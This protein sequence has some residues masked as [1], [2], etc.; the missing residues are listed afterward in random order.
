MMNCFHANRRR[1]AA[2]V[3]TLLLLYCAT[4]L[5]Q[6]APLP[7]ITSVSAATNSPVAGASDLI[8]IMVSPANQ[9]GATPTGTVAVVVD[10]TTVNSSIPLANGTATY[11]FSANSGSHVITAYYSGDQTYAAST[12]TITLAIAQKSFVISATSLTVAVGSSG[13]STITVTPLNGY[14][15]TISFTVGANSQT[16]IPCFTAPDATVSGTTPVNVSLTIFTKASACPK[17]AVLNRERRDLFTASSLWPSNHANDTASLGAAL[18]ALAFLVLIG[19]VAQHMNLRLWPTFCLLAIIVIAAGCGSSSSS[20][21]P[22]GTYGLSVSGVDKSANIAA[23][24]NLVL[25]VQ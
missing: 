7:T 13:V 20:D 14:T 1:G 12:G 5:A 2:L 8:T 9:S 11:T 15:G 25:T 19:C 24:A 4:A 10:S 21:V 18:L 3:G 17:S 23:S 6:G 22:A 16:Q